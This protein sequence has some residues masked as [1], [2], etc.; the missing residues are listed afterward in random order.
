MPRKMLGTMTN[1]EGRFD[2]KYPAINKEEQLLVLAT[3]YAPFTQK[4][5]DLVAANDS[6]IW[7]E[8][9][10]SLPVDSVFREKINPKG[11]I[12]RALDKVGV[13]NPVQPYTQTGFYR[14]VWRQD[15][16]TSKVMEAVLKLEKHPEPGS[17]ELPEKVK[18]LKGR[19]FE[20]TA[21]TSQL[22]ESFGFENGAAMLTHSIDTG[23]PEYWEGKN[24]DDYSFTLDEWTWYN[25]RVLGKISFKP[26]NKKLRAGRQGIVWVDTTTLALVRISYEFTPEG[27]KDIVKTTLGTL[28]GRTKAEVKRFHGHYAYVSLGEKQ[29]LQES[30]LVLDMEFRPSK[31]DTLRA[32]IAIQF[33][34]NDVNLRILTP[35]KESELLES[36]DALPRAGGKY[37]E[38][39]WQNYNYLCANDIEKNVLPKPKK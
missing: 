22:D 16:A 10:P 36:T 4:M 7:L 11:V 29:F 28:T 3:G 34:A 6:I 23:L 19:K 13:N 33:V 24:L 39:F 18:L 2:F 12:R 21:L 32:S 14:E 31:T 25:N 35:L 38:A 30:G 27:M 26:T 8:A 1:T 20:N 17:D 5:S 15:S 37:D 9:V